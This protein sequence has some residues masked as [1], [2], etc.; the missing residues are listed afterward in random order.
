MLIYMIICLFHCRSG[1]YYL[2]G[3]CHSKLLNYNETIRDFKLAETYNYSDAYN[4]II[5][6]LVIYFL[7]LLYLCLSS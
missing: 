1:N 2:R 7:L 5:K 4:L 3:I 6:R